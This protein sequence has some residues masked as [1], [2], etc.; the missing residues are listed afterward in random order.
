MIIV[1]HISPHD[2]A[3]ANTLYHNDMVFSTRA[4]PDIYIIISPF[5][6]FLPNIRLADRTLFVK[7]S[8]KKA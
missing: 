6:I 8:S 5:H 4:I 2:Y 3:H 1:S 7:K